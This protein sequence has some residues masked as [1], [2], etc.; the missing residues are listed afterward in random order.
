MNIN[1][2][3][4]AIDPSSENCNYIRNIAEF[5]N[6]NIIETALSDKIK[7]LSTNDNIRH[8]SFVNSN[9]GTSGKYKITNSSL[10]IFLKNKII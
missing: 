3:I 9:Q 1:N 10:D 7:L 6:I 5:N 2:I 8:C 4:Y